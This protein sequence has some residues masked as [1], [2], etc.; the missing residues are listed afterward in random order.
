MGHT[1]AQGEGIAVLGEVTPEFAQ[2][3]TPQALNFL[4]KL[5]R[6]FEGRRRELMQA[7]QARQAEFDAGRRPDFLPQTRQIREER[8]SVAPAPHDLLDRRV[9]ITGPV[10]RKMIINAL[11]SGA[12]VF[13][14]DFEDACS[15]TWENMIQGQINLRD[16]VRGTISYASTGG[17]RYTLDKRTATLM[18]RPRGW[19]LPE[20]HVQV[21]GEPVSGAI[22][23]FA[24]YFF[25]NIKELLNRNTGAYF[26]LPKIESHL[27]ARL[28]NDIFNLTQ[29][30]FEIPRGT[31]RA[32]VLIETVL[33]AFEM[34]EILYELREH[35]A[36]LN[37]G[38]WDYIFSCIK[39]F[40]NDPDF[41]LA[42]RSHV[43]MTSPFMRAYAL[44][45]IKTCHRRGAHAMGGMAAQIPIKG[46]AA[47][48][49]AALAK[50][51]TDKDR[52]ATD[53]YDGTWV[54]HPKLVTVA[55]ASFDAVMPKPNQIDKQRDD[56]RVKAADL[57]AFGPEKPI[58]ELGLRMNI[59]VGLQY[60]GS[61][62]AG[63]G[64]VPIYNLMEDA[65][66]AEIARSQIWQWIRSPKGVLEDGRKVTKELFR[67]LLPQELAKIRDE[68]GDKQ[69]R[70][71]GRY[72][73]AARIFDEITTNNEF[74]EFFTLPGYARLK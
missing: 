66:T 68:L 20:K 23:D 2:I 48:N 36:G 57:L 26:Y 3:L 34:E 49:Q 12:N 7:R 32:T 8:W 65:A 38:R 1:H 67:E 44:L 56:I 25:H 21:D 9:E 29:D 53:G 14:A 4:V 55:K 54:A 43:T 61:W 46:D 62:L 22:F 51:R 5:V 30:E 58:T 74:V 33:A 73:E 15:P 60:L 70:E 64:C 42:D 45:L 50:V 28:W 35:S 18:V 6:K 13:M 41:I 27:E 72:E 19:H 69:F 63:V 39:K 16:A 10:E 24:L 31:I 52:E 17:K 37:A 40:R 47:A 11:N 71:V 59:S